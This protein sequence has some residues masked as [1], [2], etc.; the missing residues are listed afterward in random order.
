MALSDIMRREAARLAGR[1]LDLLCPPRCAA[2][3]AD[4]GAAAA[5]AGLPAGPAICGTCRRLFAGPARCTRCGGDCAHAACRGR[6]DWDGIVVLG[7]YADDLRTAVLRT[8]RPGGEP[9]AAALGGLCAERHAATLGQWRIDLVVPVPM[10]WWR[11]AVRGTTAA[12]EIARG[13][14]ATLGTT[15]ATGLVRSRCTPLQN[16][17]PSADRRGNVRGA[18]R[19]LPRTG[20][21]RVLLVDDV[22]TTGG[23]CS[24]CRAALLARGAEAVFVAAVARAERDEARS[25]W[26]DA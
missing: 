12:A 9:L 24:A 1:G 15:C 13:L 17:L 25:Q 18:F 11:R 6:A 4:L 14:A 2:C 22:V 20:G 8:K 5:P 26:T 21:R 7:A 19:A 3:G 16:R 10:H 23:T